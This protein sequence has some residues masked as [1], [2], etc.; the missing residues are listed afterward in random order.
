[1]LIV[2]QE[3]WSDFVTFEIVEVPGAP[4]TTSLTPG[5]TACEGEYVIAFG[6]GSGG[7]GCH[8]EY[9]YQV[10]S[11]GVWS[12]WIDYTEGDI[13]ETGK[14]LEVVIQS[15]RNGCNATAG[16]TDTPWTEMERIAVTPNANPPVINCPP[17]LSLFPKANCDTICPDLTLLAG[18]SVSDDCDPNPLVTQDPPV[19]A[20]LGLG[21]HS[22]ELTATDAAGNPSSCT[23]TVLVEDVYDPVFDFLNASETI[24]ADTSY[25]GA[26]ASWTEPVASDNCSASVTSS[27]SPGDLLPFGPTLVNYVAEDPSGNISLTCF[28]NITV[29]PRPDPVISGPVSVC[30]PINATYTTGEPDTHSYKWTVTEGLIVGSDTGSEVEV[31]WS[32][33]TQGTLSVEVSS[34]S[35]CS[36]TNSITVDKAPAIVTGDIIS[37]PKLNRR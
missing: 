25:C 33:T 16:C 18:F 12:P 10:D 32:G 8:D 7:V 5:N 20:T 28:I 35:G 15:R 11:G 3:P 6:E 31:V 13:I 34:G 36:I 21:T 9:R 29:N 19:G 27:F 4:T 17:P 24:D 2:L 1:M 37:N 30:T 26:Y 23:S 14:V 22:I